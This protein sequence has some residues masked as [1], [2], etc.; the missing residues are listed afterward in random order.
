MV[1][2]KS[3]ESAKVSAPARG[4][5]PAWLGVLIGLLLGLLAGA[6]V[7]WYLLKQPTIS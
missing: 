7:L 3:S 2:L 5:F 4:G 6:A 1:T